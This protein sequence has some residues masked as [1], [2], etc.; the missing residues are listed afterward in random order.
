MYKF[1]DYINLYV[2][3]VNI[4]SRICLLKSTDVQLNTVFE[5]F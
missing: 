1:K 3:S 4:M 2:I 5:M